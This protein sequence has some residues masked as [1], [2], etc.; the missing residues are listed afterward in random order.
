M[1]EFGQPKSRQ[2]S[3]GP[4]AAALFWKIGKGTSEAT[5]PDYRLQLLHPAVP[6][7]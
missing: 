7:V 6:V 1:A 2:G 3:S 4:V 5:Y